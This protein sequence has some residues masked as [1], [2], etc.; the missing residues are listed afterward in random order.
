M[1]SVTKWML[2]AA[3]IGANGD[4]I[5]RAQAYDLD[6][7]AGDTNCRAPFVCIPGLRP[8]LKGLPT[9]G[10]HTSLEG[11][12]QGRAGSS[13]LVDDVDGAAGSVGYKKGI[14][15]VTPRRFACGEVVRGY[16]VTCTT[17]PTRRS[18]SA[19]EIDTS[20]AVSGTMF[21]M[22]CLAILRGR[23]RRFADSPVGR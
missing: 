6:S 11:R 22:G 12:S 7:V 19:P 18:V 4:A 23:K 1:Y 10:M 20:V 15:S 8:N 5:A 13:P 16:S 9:N 21:V 2:V 3:L 17:G 14:S